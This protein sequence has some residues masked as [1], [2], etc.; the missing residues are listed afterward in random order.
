MNEIT[1]EETKWS[2]SGYCK[3]LDLDDIVV[4]W[5]SNNNSLTINGNI[6]EDMKSQ[7]RILATLTKAD[8]QT[9]NNIDTDTNETGQ[10]DSAVCITI[11]AMRA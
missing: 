2:S 4:R 8:S 9:T 11:I 6:S 3:M 10:D 7:L 5:Y 1:E